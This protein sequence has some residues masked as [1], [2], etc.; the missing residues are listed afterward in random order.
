MYRCGLFLTEFSGKL[1]TIRSP[2][3]EGDTSPRG[4]AELQAA[5]WGCHRHPDAVAHGT[6]SAC[7]R[8]NSMR[9]VSRA[10]LAPGSHSVS[11]G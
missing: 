7:A 11:P 3:A 4:Y 9:N 5:C 6:M 8:L 2:A 1:L 10:W